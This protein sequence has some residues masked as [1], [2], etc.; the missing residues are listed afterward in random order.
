MLLEVAVVIVHAAE[1]L[2]ANIAEEVLLLH[3]GKH[4][5]LEVELSAE[6]VAA[7]FALEL[8]LLVDKHVHFE[9]V[10]AHKALPA[11]LAHER[12]HPVVLVYVRLE[13]IL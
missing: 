1:V 12:A 5:A 4:V 13:M 2:P 3:M 7:H 6:L 10:L 8:H 11:Y 9:H